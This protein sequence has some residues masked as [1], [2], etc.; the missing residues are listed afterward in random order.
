MNKLLFYLWYRVPRYILILFLPLSVIFYLIIKLRKYSQENILKRYVSKRKV[1]IVGNLTVGGSGKT[2][3][4]IWLCNHL[5]DIGKK[6]A[7]VSSGYGSSITSPQTI[8]ESCKP[9]E[10]GD[11]AVMLKLKTNSIVVSSKDRVAST[12]HCEKYQPD[13][14]IHDDGLQHYRLDRDYEF[15]ISNYQQRAN[16]F[17]LPC[18]PYREPKS[19]H[20]NNRVIYS[21]YNGCTE[22]GFDTNISVVKSADNNSCYSLEDKKFVNS[23]LITAIADNYII[24]KQLQNYKINVTPIKYDDHYQFKETDFPDSYEPILVTEK[25]Y[26]KI[27]Q[28]NIKNIYILEQEI[29][30]NDKLM[31]MIERIL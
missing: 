10:V 3:F 20:R 28:F 26:V 18:G 2:P 6:V 30:P 31:K 22:P 1:I 11:E 15:I 29:T 5:T 16:S 23:I 19:F 14:I 13:F 4:A 27:K 21:N 25:D 9:E 8:T 12:I 7:I 24:L 17:L